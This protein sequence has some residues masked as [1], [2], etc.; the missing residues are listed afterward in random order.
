MFLCGSLVYSI[1]LKFLFNTRSK[2]GKD[3]KVPIDYWAKLDLISAVATLVGFP[4]ILSTEPVGMITKSTK[5]MLDYITL[6]LILLQW[7]RFYMFF[8]MISELSKMI[9]T[10]IAMVKESLAFMFLLLAYLIIASAIFTTIF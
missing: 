5:D 6:I 7:T 2:S 10:F 1:A 4:Y 9:L 3:Y 8:L